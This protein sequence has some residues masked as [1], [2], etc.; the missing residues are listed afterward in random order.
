MR[1]PGRTGC[2]AC[3]PPRHRRRTAPLRRTLCPSQRPHRIWAASAR[4][5]LA[6]WCSLP[7]FTST[8][9]I[10]TAIKDRCGQKRPALC[11]SQCSSV[12][13]GWIAHPEII[14]SHS[15]C[16]V[17][18]EN[19]FFAAEHGVLSGWKLHSPGAAWR[20]PAERVQAWPDAAW[21]A[22]AA[23]HVHTPHCHVPGG[24]PAARH[25]SLQHVQHG[26]P[27]CSWP[28]NLFYL[29]LHPIQFLRN[30]ARGNADV[31]S[32]PVLCDHSSNLSAC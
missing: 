16:A 28:G 22:H 9:A 21:A 10:L 19:C 8:R 20:R 27:L 25:G 12:S 6:P 3:R 11:V 2:R 24:P 4:C 32:C 26:Q 15:Y 31:L 13:V 14:D 7:S 30:P 5:P 1:W 17:C 18:P 23:H 29:P